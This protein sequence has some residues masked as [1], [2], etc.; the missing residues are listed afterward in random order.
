VTALQLD[1]FPD[2]AIRHTIAARRDYGGTLIRQCSNCGLLAAAP[3]AGQYKASDQLGAC[4]RCGNEGWWRQWFGV[5]GVGAFCRPG[6][7]DAVDR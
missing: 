5:D 6:D 1:L 3:D 4:P 2:L 7:P